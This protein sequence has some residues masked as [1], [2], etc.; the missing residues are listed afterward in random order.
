MERRLF[1]VEDD[2]DRCKVF[3][4]GSEDWEKREEGA[5]GKVALLWKTSVGE[6]GE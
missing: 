3:S 4:W 2:R 1:P 6:I 5:E